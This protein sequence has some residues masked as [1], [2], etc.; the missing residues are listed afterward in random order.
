MIIG[1]LPNVNSINSESGCKFG[2]KFS[3][4]HRQVEGQP[5]KKQKKD[6]TKMQWLS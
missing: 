2:E 3:F 4:A 5:P 6:V 1:I